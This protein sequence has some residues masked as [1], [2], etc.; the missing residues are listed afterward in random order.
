MATTES[1]DQEQ[2]LRLQCKF[3]IEGGYNTANIGGPF[4]AVFVTDKRI[5]KAANATDKYLL[6]LK[7]PLRITANIEIFECIFRYQ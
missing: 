3:S 5:G 2:S 7:G 4:V 1:G 6:S